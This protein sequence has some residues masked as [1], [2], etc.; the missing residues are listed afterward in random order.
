MTVFYV[1][2]L[3][4]TVL[5]E[6][7][8]DKVVREFWVT[9]VEHNLLCVHPERLLAVME[10]KFASRISDRFQVSPSRGMIRIK[11]FTQI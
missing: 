2:T 8:E 6:L 4:T 3:P 11:G 5:S 10:Q 7:T 1:F 9:S